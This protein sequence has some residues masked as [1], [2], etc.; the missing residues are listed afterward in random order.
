MGKVVPALGALGRGDVG[1]RPAR[2]PY[3]GV[4]HGQAHRRPGPRRLYGQM[5]GDVRPDLVMHGLAHLVDIAQARG[6][7]AH[8][9]PFGGDD[10]RLVQRHPVLDPVAEGIDDHG[11]VIAEPAGDVGVRPSP[12]PEQ[13]GGHVPMEQGDKGLDTGAQQSVHQAVV[14][15]QTGGVDGSGA[16]GHDAGPAQREPVAVEP[17]IF[18]Q[19]HVLRP[20]VVMVGRDIPGLALISGARRVGKLV[21]HATAGPIGQRRALNLIGRRGRAPVEPPVVT[22]TRLGHKDLPVYKLGPSLVENLGTFALNS[23]KRAG[24]AEVGRCK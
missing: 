15:A 4:V 10:E 21:P 11:G 6:V 9:V 5:A 8:Q 7:I 23:E 14:E 20:P 22:H 19:L 18:H 3:G 17:H 13:G 16:L 1:V 12:A 2:R 24:A